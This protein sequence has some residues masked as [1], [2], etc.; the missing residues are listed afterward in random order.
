MSR[1]RGSAPTDARPGALPPPR[2]LAWL[3][4]Q[5]P[6]TSPAGTPAAGRASEAAAT[7]AR[8]AQDPEVQRVMVLVRRFVEIVEIVRARTVCPGCTAPARALRVRFDAWLTESLTSD[9]RALRTF[10][11]GL[12]NDGTAVRAALTTAWSNAQADGHSTKLKR[13]KR[14]MYG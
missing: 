6:A 9:V 12:A 5:P 11:T 1:G 7:V 10:A 13:L 3:V 4:V 8:I 14:Q 2:H